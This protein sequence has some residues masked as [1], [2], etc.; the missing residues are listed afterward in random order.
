MALS[1][2][3]YNIYIIAYITY[4]VYIIVPGIYYMWTAWIAEMNKGIYQDYTPRFIVYM[5][6]H[7]FVY[8]YIAC[9]ISDVVLCVIQDVN[10]RT[11]VAVS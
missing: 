3:I 11:V 1:L 6:K 8:I 5:N 10:R 9:F 4:A 7:Y 2:S